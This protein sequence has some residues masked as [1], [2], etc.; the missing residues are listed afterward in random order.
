MC[1]QCGGF[2]TECKYALQ[3]LQQDFSLYSCTKNIS[4]LFQAACSKERGSGQTEKKGK[5]KETDGSDEK[6]VDESLQQDFH[7]QAELHWEKS[8]S[9]EQSIGHSRSRPSRWWCSRDEGSAS[10]RPSWC[11]LA[12]PLSLV[13]QS[14]T[15]GEVHHWIR[16]ATDTDIQVGRSCSWHSTLLTNFL[17]QSCSVKLVQAAVSSSECSSRHHTVSPHLN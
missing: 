1:L 2:K 3:Q 11:W 12:C 17:S 14:D 13:L 8:T 15:E 4:L 10:P 5:N 7:Q 16:G 6:G 9:R